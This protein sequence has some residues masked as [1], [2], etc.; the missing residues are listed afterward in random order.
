MT[1]YQQIFVVV[2]LVLEGLL[3]VLAFVKDRIKISYSFFIYLV[4]V[5]VSD[6][7]YATLLTFKMGARQFY[8]VKEFCLD[9]IKIG[10]AL[11]L[12]Q[13]IFKYYPRVKSSNLIGIIGAAIFFLVYHW[14]TPQKNLDW[15]FSIPSDIHSKILQATC[16]SFLYMSGSI[17][18]YR[19]QI[20]GAY[21]FLM[22]GFLLSQL[23]LALGFAIVA[24]FGQKARIPLSY[25][26]SAFFLLALIVWIR[27][28]SADD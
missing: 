18:F 10:M 8:V 2:C 11:E 17:L 1:L 16:I 13:K 9:A 23:P 28:Y 24:A 4:L 26:N 7:I 27:V 25:F 20:T 19:L 3:L 22:S 5:F 6:S 15:W 12:S 21:K 14:L